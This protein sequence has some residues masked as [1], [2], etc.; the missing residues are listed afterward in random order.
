MRLQYTDVESFST[1]E[2]F[3][4]FLRPIDID[5]CT[6]LRHRSRNCQWQPYWQ[7]YQPGQSSAVYCC[8]MLQSS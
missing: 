7:Q 4:A 8:R 3:A 5:H 6:Y 2:A 1:K